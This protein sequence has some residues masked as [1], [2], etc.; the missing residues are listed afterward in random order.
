MSFVHLHNHTHFSLLDGL[1]KPSQYI[2]IAQEQN[3]P[4]VA[5][6]D[7]GNLY[8]LIEF[9]QK[10]K[11]ADIKPIL[12]CE[13]YITKGNRTERKTGP[14]NKNYHLVL[15][16]ENNQG[17]Q[18]LIQLI[19]KAH[20]EG[21]YYRPRIDFE[22]LK[23]YSKGLIGLSAC[24][25]GEIP[26][27][28]LTGNDED[29]VA[30][31]RKY[32]AVFGSEN[33]FLEIQDHPEIT[34]Q[35]ESN[36]ALIRLAK[37]TKAPLVATNDCHYPRSEDAEAH[38]VL[39]C[40]QTQ[41]NVNDENRLNYPGDYSM[42]HPKD[43]EEAFPN[44]PEAIQNTV[45]IADRCNVEL[46]FK[47]NLIPAYQTPKNEKPHQYLKQ[48]CEAGMKKRYGEKPSDE[49]Q[50]RLKYEL[51]LIHKM[52]Y[53]TYFLI[54]QDFVRFAKEADIMVGPGR[55]SA[56]GSIISYAL[57][58][59]DIDPLQ[60]NLLFERFLN[61]E[62]VSMP[63]I[64]IDFA[65]NRR[66]EVLDYVV[67]KYGQDK[68]AQIVTFGTM[69]ARAAVRD[70]G[71][72]LG[73]SYSDVDTIAKKI[74]A[75]PGTK[76]QEAIET[77]TELREIYEAT[78]ENKKLI[79]TALKLEGVVRHASVHAC[80]VIIA[81]KPLIE[82]TPL[83]R[84][85]GDEAVISQYSMKPIEDIGIL[86]MDFL[87]LKNLTI[88]Q[89]T[90]NIIKRT[91]KQDVNITKIPLDDAKTFKLM[92]RAET[93]GVFQFESAGMKRYLKDLKPTR[94]EDLIAMNALYRPGPMDWIPDYIKGKH[95]QDKIKYFHPSF[96]SILEE[97]YGV[98]VYQEQILEIAKNFAGFTL[99][100]ADILRK[101]VGK[102][103]TS[104]LAKQ[105][106]KFIEG[107]IKKGHTKRFAI[108][109][110]EKVIEPFAGYG[111]NKSHSA[112][113]AMIAY[114]TAYLKTHY[115]AEFMAA[116]LTADQS[117]TDRI[118]IEIEECERMGITV[119]PPDI[120]ESLANFTVVDDNTI[121]FGLNAIKGVGQGTV[122]TIIEALSKGEKFKSIDDFSL[123]VP[124]K[125]LNKKTLEALALSGALDTLGER[126][127]IA[128]ST[129]EIV[130][131]A[132]NAQ[133][134][135]TQGQTDIFSIMS[136]EDQQAPSFQLSKIPPATPFQKLQ[137]E[138]TYL[139]LYVSGHPL[140]GLKKY[141]G[142]KIHFIEK[143]TS[144]EVGHSLKIGG[145]ISRI[146]K[147]TT[148]SGTHMAYLTLEDPTGQM[149]VTIF[150]KTYQA[151][152]EAFNE[153]QIV[154][155][156]GRVEMRRGELQF[157]CHETKALSLENMIQKAKESGFYNLKDKVKRVV[158]KTEEE[159]EETK[160]TK[161]SDTTKASA[162]TE[163]LAYTIKIP[164]NADSQLL[165]KIKSL[166]QD[167]QGQQSV[168][169]AITGGQV[170]KRIKVPFGVS[171]NPELKK[172][173]KAVL[174]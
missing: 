66:D 61:P 43:I 154:V 1:A 87:G 94:L 34:N 79:D 161:S 136:P 90:V 163:K 22:L 32:Q 50:K 26:Q 160:E 119:L 112:C 60:Y 140:D 146:K 24:I 162:S 73:V 137:W 54:V 109:V 173:V 132:K 18:N 8:G 128:S 96:K 133:A 116:L 23:E 114:Q 31:I 67:E 13:A 14:E 10:A 150:P 77:E 158:K 35:N 166:L 135:Y 164:A 36:Q 81:E 138:K 102:K 122:E 52:G 134:S 168:E 19:T 131:Y 15:L 56:A 70:V 5:I 145:L 105:R 49:A 9:Y 130:I 63:D 120:N 148:R 93:T 47:Q 107:A 104:L 41:T 82:Y 103:I 106:T 71:R 30:T 68:V 111:F 6:T 69:A 92:A 80:A 33:F 157:I 20:L 28:A 21:F 149:D 141:L 2:K 7:H 121:R 65:D 153:D 4:A 169:I 170:L 57:G 3:A 100:E 11:S 144:R 159:I 72:G 76:L 37:E 139:G 101:A 39:I 74:P 55:G 174:Q 29:A 129:E 12:G 124:I 156:S 155:M 44:V 147:I 86:K 84:A 83:Q 125:A 91:K 117:N 38:D 110:F 40:I 48:I 97:T 127:A 46:K 99:G 42:R 64:D 151:Y 89:K 98:A 75:R 58:I 123:R 53:D 51:E 113:Y 78:P 17:Y 88:L 118:V 95:N 152:R 126:K 172:K 167:H 115:P 16:A 25:Q 108:D 85:P 45:A 171:L 142:K 143:I 27:I 62:R 165:N 59:T